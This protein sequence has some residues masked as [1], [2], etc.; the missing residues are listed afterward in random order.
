MQAQVREI[1]SFLTGTSADVLQTRFDALAPGDPIAENLKA[2]ECII[3]TH[4]LVDLRASLTLLGD[5]ALEATF[6]V[7][8][9]GRVSSGKSSLLNAFIGAQVLPTGI[10]PMTSVPTRL[11]RGSTAAI[12]VTYAHGRTV[13][14]DIHRLGEF[15]TEAHN[16]GTR[17]V[18]PGSVWI[19]GRV[20]RRPADLRVPAAM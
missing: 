14:Y 15:V 2:L 13:S 5:R 6:E 8:V 19:T 20:T 17:S 4:G 7:A 11:H 3:T 16:P 1:E 9:V 10:L 12:H 18:S